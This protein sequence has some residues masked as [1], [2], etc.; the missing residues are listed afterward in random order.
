MDEAVNRFSVHVSDEI[1]RF[2]PRFVR[3]SAVFYVLDERERGIVTHIIIGVC[4]K[5]IFY[6]LKKKKKRGFRGC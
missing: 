4:R 6:E 3:R 1:S 5:R 2:Q